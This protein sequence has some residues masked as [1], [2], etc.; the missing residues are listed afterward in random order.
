VEEQRP[1]DGR[2]LY[3]GD[4]QGCREELERL[5]E[6]LRYDPARDRIEPAGDFVN[7]GPDSAGVLRLMRQLS[8]GGVL[9]NHDVHLLRVARGVKKARPGDTFGDVL[10]ADD[11]DELLGWLAAKPLVVAEPDVVLVH[12]GINPTWR[13][14]VATLSGLDPLREDADLAFAV[15]ARYCDE[16]GARPDEDWPPPPAP[17]RPWFE[18]WPRDARERR[19]VVF[20]HWARAG[21]VVRPLV[22]GLDTGCVWGGRLSAW[23]AEEDRIV[24]VPARRAYAEHGAA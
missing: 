13:D 18:F 7:R 9:G 19:T 20:G 1:R 14:P 12:A 5:L 2:R 11:R 21:L 10:T 24:Q 3:V 8:A 17:F 4:V 22:R 23:I 15:A 16:R 6:A